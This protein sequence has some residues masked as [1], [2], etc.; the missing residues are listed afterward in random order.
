MVIALIRYQTDATVSMLPERLEYDF[1]EGWSIGSLDTASASEIT[2]P[3][4]EKQH[5]TE[6]MVFQNTLSEDFVGMTMHFST[7]NANVRVVLDGEEIYRKEESIN[8]DSEHFVDIPET[9]ADG[10]DGF[11]TGDGCG[12]RRGRP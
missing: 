4:I 1:N 5:T 6:T 12:D 8:S 11:G 7:E 10:I 2:L 3:Y 9:C